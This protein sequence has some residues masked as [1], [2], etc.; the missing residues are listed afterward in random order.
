MSRLLVELDR[1]TPKRRG[2]E[3]ALAIQEQSRFHRRSKHLWPLG[4]SGPRCEKVPE[5][6]QMP[7]GSRV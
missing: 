6:H 2:F 3:V 4:L 1:R 5:I 7:C